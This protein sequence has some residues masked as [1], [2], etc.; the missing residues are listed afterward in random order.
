MPVLKWMWYNLWRHTRGTL[1]AT[2]TMDWRRRKRKKRKKE[3]SW[4]GMEEGMIDWCLDFYVRK[5][6]INIQ[7]M[8]WDDMIISTAVINPIQ[9]L[10]SK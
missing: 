2:T 6:S 3:S 8:G 9:K 10:E 7:I 4:D 5:V 1:R